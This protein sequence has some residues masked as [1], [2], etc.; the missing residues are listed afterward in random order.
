MMTFRNL[1]AMLQLWLH[2]CQMD[3]TFPQYH[4]L[5]RNKVILIVDGHSSHKNLEALKFAKANGVILLGLPAHSTNRMY[6]LVL[7]PN[8]LNAYSGRT[9]G[10]QQVAGIFRNAYG[11]A[12]SIGNMNGFEKV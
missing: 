6:V 1:A 7:Q 4:W 8:E 3:K 9:I 11:S 5:Q 12:A 2:G 10:L